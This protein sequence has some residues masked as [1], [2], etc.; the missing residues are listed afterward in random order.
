MITAILDAFRASV[1]VS[2]MFWATFLVLIFLCGFLLNLVARMVRGKLAAYEDEN[3]RALQAVAKT[4]EKMETSM[5]VQTT[6]LKGSI[7][8]LNNLMRE[9]SEDLRNDIDETKRLMRANEGYVYEKIDKSAGRL[10]ERVNTTNNNLA[11]LGKKVEGMLK[12]C[13]ICEKICPHRG[14]KGSPCTAAA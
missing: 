13:E 2:P 14:G 7:D 1:Q 5:S 10:H 11:D 3:T 9:I 12:V 8:K 6:E 4:M